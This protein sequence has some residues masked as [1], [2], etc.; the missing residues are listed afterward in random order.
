MVGYRPTLTHPCRLMCVLE[1]V[2][3]E[4]VEYSIVSFTRGSYFEDDNNGS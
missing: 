2:F 1:Y 3:D 4:R